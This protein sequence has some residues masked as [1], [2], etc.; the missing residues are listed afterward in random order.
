V[1]RI[2]RNEYG[3]LKEHLLALAVR[4]LVTL[5]ILAGIASVPLEARAASKFLG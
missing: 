1:R 4:N 5:L 2:R 3:A